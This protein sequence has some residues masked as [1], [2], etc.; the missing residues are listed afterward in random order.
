M[1]FYE[2]G[3]KLWSILSMG[4]YSL[5]KSF[6][7]PSTFLNPHSN[8]GNYLGSPENT[9]RPLLID[10]LWEC[11]LKTNTSGEGEE[12]ARLDKREVQLHSR[13]KQQLCPTPNFSFKVNFSS[14]AEISY[15]SCLIL[16]LKWPDLYDPFPPVIAYGL[17]PEGHGLG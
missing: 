4:N 14:E 8:L 12:A 1:L 2:R 11:Y 6:I 9:L 7:F 3:N 17:P 15:Q 16:S 13:P 5:Q 10:V